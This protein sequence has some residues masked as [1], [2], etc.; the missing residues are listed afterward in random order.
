MRVGIGAREISSVP[1]KL[2]NC[3]ACQTHACLEQ[4]FLEKSVEGLP[5]APNIRQ[6]FIALHAR[7]CGGVHLVESAA[8]A[9]ADNASKSHRVPQQSYSRG[10]ARPRMHGIISRGDATARAASL[11]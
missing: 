7:S 1:T 5:P 8:R 9:G 4:D 11:I 3:V 10:G 2:T 6:Q